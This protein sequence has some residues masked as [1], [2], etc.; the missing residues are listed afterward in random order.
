LNTKVQP[1]F[2]RVLAFLPCLALVA[3][4]SSAVAQSV[5][6]NFN[7]L[8]GATLQGGR[9]LFT[10]NL[11]VTVSGSASVVNI[12]SNFPLVLDGRFN[13]DGTTNTATI[14]RTSGTGPIFYIHSGASLTLL[15]LTLTGGLNTN[16]GAIYSDTGS[17]LIISNCVFSGNMAT[18][19]AGVAGINGSTQNGGNNNGGSGGDGFGAA[20][21]AIYSRGSVKCYDSVFTGNSAIGGNGGDGGNGAPS[22]FFGGNAGNGG[23]G[24]SAQGGAV[25]CL[26]PS[27]VFVATDFVQNH[28]T[29]GSG[30]N[31]GTQASGAFSGLPG[32]GGTGGGGIGGGLLVS[33]PLFMTNCLFSDNMVTA[34]ATRAFSTPGGSASG[35]GLAITSSTNSAFIENTT[36]VDNSCTGGAG[37]GNTSLNFDPAGNGGAATGGGLL[38]AAASAVIRNCTFATNFLTGGAGGTSS[39]SQSNGI[40]GIVRGADIARTAGGV[41]MANTILSGGTNATVTNLTTTIFTTYITN[42]EPNDAGGLTDLGFNFSSDTTVAF[43]PALGGT[44]NGNPYLDSVLSSPGGTAVGLRGGPSGQTL[45]VLFGSPCVGVIPGIPGITFPAYDQVYQPRSTPTCI[46]AYEANPLDTNIVELP[47]IDTQPSNSFNNAGSMAQFQI[48]TNGSADLLIGFQW[49]HNGTNLVDGGRVSG[50]WSTNLTIN[51][52][53]TND[54]GTYTVLLGE[55][56]L[57]S[58]SIITSRNATLTVFVPVSITVQPPRSV[59]PVPGLPVNLSVTATGAAPLSFQ[60]L[61]NGQPLSD[62]TMVEITGATNSSLS[63]YPL[64]T[65]D[66]GVYSVIVSNPYSSVTSSNV[67][68]NIPA[69]TLT[70]L[71]TMVSVTDPNLNLMGTASG[72]FGVTNVQYQLN[73]TGY[74][75]ASTSTNWTQWNVPLILEPGTNVIS[76]FATD[77]LGQNSRTNTRTVFYAS[78]NALTLATNGFGR[79]T[80]N[81]TGDPGMLVD[82]RYYSVTAVPSPGNLFSS[83]TVDTGS[84]PTTNF[85]NPFILF[86]T[87]DVSLTAS[88]VTNFFIPA[89]GAYNG[90]FSV[91]GGVAEETS[92]MIALTLTSSGSFSGHLFID[93]TSFPLSG[94]FDANGNATVTVRSSSAFSSGALTVTL[95]LSSLYH[96]IGVPPTSYEIAGT[97]ANGNNWSADFYAG[98]ASA[99]DPSAVY[100]AFLA[101]T[102]SPITSGAVPLGDGYA[103]IANHAGQVTISGALADGTTFTQSVPVQGDGS[104]PIYASLYHNTGLLFGWINLYDL[105]GG[106]PT[107]S[108]TWIKKAS[109][110]STPFPAGLTN[111]LLVEGG[112]W[113]APTANTPAIPFT[114]GVLVVSNSNLSLTFDVAVGNNNALVKLGNLPTNSLTGS[115]N[116]LTGAL[117]VVFGNGTGRATSTGAGAVLQ[118]SNSAAGYFVIGTNAGLISLSTNAAD[119][120]PIIFQGPANQNFEAGSDASFS[121]LALGTSPLSYQW[122][123]NGNNLA[124]GGNISGSATSQLNITAGALA[125]SG[126]Y[127]VIVTNIFGSATSAVAVLAVPPPSIAIT[128]GLSTVTNYSLTIDG[129]VS[130]KFGVAGVQ[131]QLNG[132]SWSNALLSNPSNWSATVTLTAGTNLFAAYATDP[133]GHRSTTNTVSVFYLTYGSIALATN[134]PGRITANF[135]GNQLAVGRN[136]TVTALPAAGNVFSN[137]TGSLTSHANPLTFQMV[138]NMTLV[139]TFSSNI[140]L[141]SAGVYNGLFYASNEVDVF[142]AGMIQNLTLRTN[143]SYSGRLLLAGTNYPLAGAFDATGLSDVNAGPLAVSL[144]L[145]QSPTNQI[146]GTVSGVDFGT[147]WTANVLTGIAGTNHASAE[148]TMLFVSSGDTNAPPG[149]SYALVTNHAGA[150]TFSAALAD[151]SSFSENV[152]ASPTGDIPIYAS[153][154]PGLNSGLFFGWVN[155]TNFEVNAPATSLTWIKKPSAATLRY[156]AGFTNIV[157]LQASRWTVPAANAPA[158]AVPRGTLAIFTNSALL[159][160]IQYT[161]AVLGNNTVEKLGGAPTNSLT[162]TIKPATGMLTLTFGNGNGTA[163]TQANGVILQDANEAA[164]FYLT[165]TNSDGFLLTR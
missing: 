10:S 157:G 159:S 163:T 97:V 150:F 137:W 105:N 114:N 47:E 92:G 77:I 155:Y 108:L 17:T 143:G 1:F 18:N 74:F 89:A 88:F 36:F 28:A 63:I 5:I 102:N 23:S 133:V 156:V 115:I 45:A 93:G 113:T 121:V 79:I 101:G 141:A 6:S 39:T 68:L 147:N 84:G 82:G 162:G 70:V 32:N 35:G 142:S 130:G 91:A 136:Y 153:P 120:A 37:G 56:T 65:N 116:P 58:D 125:D 152:P 96:Q 123:F 78:Y 139:A 33:G 119:L 30:G 62:T 44:V 15:N 122:L 132:G 87:S 110:L 146:T 11:T 161:V 13:A 100:T 165:P 144:T 48:A 69:P 66:A 20:G 129:T 64:D 99:G 109:G 149:Q 90:L 107:D 59:T 126:S 117:S 128:R 148:Y 29:G 57:V 52:V 151:G 53:T 46:G 8:N 61:L 103:L 27:N 138:S 40:P 124:D 145:Q 16:G 160:P 24:G 49:R 158:I 55:S 72:E 106:A 104:V 154:Y 54:A 81:F 38:T 26:G 4:A 9:W 131:Y 127:S 67:T 83:W 80:R 50:S 75:P 135:T 22:G 42:T 164:G 98:Q 31:Q 19:F 34:G 14:T 12:F 140:F 118:S 41:S 60:W 25:V 73:G 85:N 2:T 21:G 43:S 95:T 71:P 76:I 51:P 112:P 86:L 134:G 7:S 111:L 94:V 3:L